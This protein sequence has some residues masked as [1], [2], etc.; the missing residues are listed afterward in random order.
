MRSNLASLM[1]FLFQLSHR[2]IHPKLHINTTALSESVKEKI[3]MRVT[4]ARLRKA[5]RWNRP[6]NPPRSD[7][8]QRCVAPKQSGFFKAS[9]LAYRKSHEVRDVHYPILAKASR[10]Q[11]ALAD[12]IPMD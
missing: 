1:Q 12:P 2:I 4:A 10:K 6:S 8:V 11:A 3:D 9:F 5:N 7:L